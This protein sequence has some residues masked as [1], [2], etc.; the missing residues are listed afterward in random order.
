MV[1]REIDVPG[2]EREFLRFGVL[3]G[4]RRISWFQKHRCAKVPEPCQLRESSPG[5]SLYPLFPL[6]SEG[7]YEGSATLE[8]ALNLWE[9]E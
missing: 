2:N 1:L 3:F 5:L 9:K 4:S 6:V 8:G 7:S